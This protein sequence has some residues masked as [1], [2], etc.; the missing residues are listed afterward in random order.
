MIIVVRT[1]KD[2]VFFS[3]NSVPFA[4]FWNRKENFV[5]PNFPTEKKTNRVPNNS[6]WLWAWRFLKSKIRRSE[7]I[8]FF[9]SK[10]QRFAVNSFEA[11]FFAPL[12]PIFG[13]VLFFQRCDDWETGFSSTIFIGLSIERERREKISVR[14]TFLF[15]VAFCWSNIHRSLFKWITL[16]FCSVTTYLRRNKIVEFLLL[17]FLRLTLTECF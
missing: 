13:F 16:T 1:K 5:L 6:C 10:N 15:L 9:E 7:K 3:T 4:N 12:L 14:Q 2:L 8:F 17:V 11:P